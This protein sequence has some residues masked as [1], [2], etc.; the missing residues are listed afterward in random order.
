[1][2]LVPI[3]Q[4]FTLEIHSRS[5]RPHLE[6][7]LV[8]VTISVLSE[9]RHQSIRY[10]IFTTSRHRVTDHD[11]TVVGGRGIGSG[12]IELGLDKSIPFSGRRLTH[13]DRH[14]DGQEI[15]SERD[16]LEGFGEPPRDQLRI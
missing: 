4:L 3:L 2:F 6:I 8:P 14:D 7:S 15:G 10:S 1:L 9:E 13:S 16:L 5:I 11:F 12:K